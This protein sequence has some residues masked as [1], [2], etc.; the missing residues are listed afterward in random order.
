MPPSRPTPTA[1]STR[2]RSAIEEVIE[3]AGRPLAPAEVLELARA[4]TPSLS[5][6]TVYRSLRRLLDEERIIAVEMPGAPARYE[7]ASL[8]HH[9]HF[10]CDRCDRVYDVEGCPG[11][12][13]G[14]L[15]RGFRLRDHEILLLGTCATCAKG[16]A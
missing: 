6:A 14:L 2:Q 3:R 10:R 1:R 11:N 13:A 7:P 16:R 15:P 9:H 8:S 5:L 12:L 4:R